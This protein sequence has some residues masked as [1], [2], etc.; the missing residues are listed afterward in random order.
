MME[1]RTLEY[2]LAVAREQ[3]ITAAAEAMHISQPAL[4]RQIKALEDELGKQLLIRGVKGSR[5]VMLTEEGQILRHRAE[6]IVSLTRRTE[7]EITG[8]GDVIAGT[9]FIGAGETDSLRIFARVADGIREEHPDIKFSMI[10]GNAEQIMEQ[11]EKGLIDF[12]LVFSEINDPRY[13]TLSVPTVDKWGVLMRRD[14]P[15]AEKDFV[16]PEDLWDKPLLIPMQRSDRPFIYKWM[17]KHKSELNEVVTYNL[18]YNA[19]IFVDESIGYALCFDK[20]INTE[21]TRLCFRPLN[22]PLHSYGTVVWKKYQAM[23]KASKKFLSCLKALSEEE[24][25]RK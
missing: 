20:L 4:S 17:K 19:S 18:V 5:R 21:G 8:S 25:E 3:N 24:E 12:G 1:L 16:E 10:S 11:L 15:L 2:F 23:S 13:E 22:P 9:V 6:E 14:S 7:E